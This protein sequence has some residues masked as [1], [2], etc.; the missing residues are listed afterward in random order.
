M[1]LAFGMSTLTRTICDSPGVR[2][3]RVS[4]AV[5]VRSVTHGDRVADGVAFPLGAGVPDF[6]APDAGAPDGGRP[7]GAAG[8]EA[9]PDAVVVADDVDPAARASPGEW[10]GVAEPH[11]A[12]LSSSA[13]G[14]S[15][16]VGNA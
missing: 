5:T 13:R 12:R 14:S 15:G 8:A 3:I 9:V 1:T 6:T 10:L 7:V 16:R 4:F 2:Q 11:A